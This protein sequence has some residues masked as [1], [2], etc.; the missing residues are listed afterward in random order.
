MDRKPT[1]KQQRFIDEYI[2]D[3]NGAQAAIRAGYSERTARNIASDLLA[4]PHIKEAVEERQKALQKE[5]QIT[6]ER[7][8]NELA[9]IGFAN[10][11]DSSMKDGVKYRASSKLKALELMARMTGVLDKP[12]DSGADVE[13]VNQNILSLAELIKNPKPNREIPSEDE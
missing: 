9:Q 10:S 1:K 4:N 8:L 12:K 11:T 5:T 3:F 7:I 13:Q 6:Q 2:I